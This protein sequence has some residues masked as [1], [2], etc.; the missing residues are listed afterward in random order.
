MRLLNV[1]ELIPAGTNAIARRRS[2]QQAL[3]IEISK[4]IN[5]S[6]EARNIVTGDKVH[7]TLESA[8][9]DDWEFV[10]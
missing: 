9:A 5:G 4:R 1:A 10:H 8:S 6:F 7:I 3:C 2:W